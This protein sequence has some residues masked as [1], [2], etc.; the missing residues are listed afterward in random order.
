MKRFETIGLTLMKRTKGSADFHGDQIA[1]ILGDPYKRTLAAQ[2]LGQA[3]VIAFN[4]VLANK[5]GIERIAGKLI[6]EREIYGDEL[7][8]LLDAQNLTQPELDFTKDETWPK[9]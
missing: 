5:E 1:S 7:L 9:M 4:F 6:A 2:I 8:D 3:Y